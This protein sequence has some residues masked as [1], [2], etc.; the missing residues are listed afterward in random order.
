MLDEMFADVLQLSSINENYLSLFV[1]LANISQTNSI[2]W[3]D[4]KDLDTRQKCS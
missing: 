1:R 3:N 4:V 2:H